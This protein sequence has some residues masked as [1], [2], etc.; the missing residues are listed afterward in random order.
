MDFERGNSLRVG[1]SNE[2]GMLPTPEPQDAIALKTS[3][4]DAAS[5]PFLKQK[6]NLIESA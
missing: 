2:N 6:Q 4:D 1:N 5:A 3:A